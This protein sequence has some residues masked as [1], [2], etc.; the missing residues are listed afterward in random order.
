MAASR[1]DLSYR[2]SS[3]EEPTSPTTSI[4]CPIRRDLIEDEEP[5]DSYSFL[6]CLSP[7]G[8]SLHEALLEK[9]KTTETAYD[10]TTTVLVQ[11]GESPKCASLASLTNLAVEENKVE[12]YTRNDTASTQ[13]SNEENPPYT[14]TSLDAA[15]VGLMASGLAWVRRRKSNRYGGSRYPIDRKLQQRQEEIDASTELLQ[16]SS[17]DPSPGTPLR[18]AVSCPDGHQELEIKSCPTSPSFM[19]HASASPL[20]SL[21]KIPLASNSTINNTSKS[22]ASSPM[23]AELAPRLNPVNNIY[24]ISSLLTGSRQSNALPEDTQNDSPGGHVAFLQPESK[25]EEE[26]SIAPASVV[27]SLG[28]FCQDDSLKPKGNDKSPTRSALA[29]VFSRI[30]SEFTDQDLDE[31]STDEEEDIISES[32][33]EEDI[34][35]VAWIPQVRTVAE[36]TAR[37]NSCILTPLQMHQIARHVLPKGIAA[38]QWKCIYSLARD[39]DSFDVCLHYARNDR[40]TLLVVRTTRGAVFGG[41]AG[42]TWTRNGEAHYYGNNETCLFTFEEKKP[43]TLP[44]TEPEVVLPEDPPKEATTCEQGGSNGRHKD[45]ADGNSPTREERENIRPLE[46]DVKVT[47]TP[48][49]YERLTRSG[50]FPVTKDGNLPVTRARSTIAAPLSPPLVHR[51]KKSLVDDDEDS[52]EAS[53]PPIRV[54]KYKGVNRYIQYC[55]ANRKMLAFGGGG[56]E[57]SFGLCVQRE[58]QLGSTGHCDTFDNEPL[59]EQE[60]FKIVDVELWGFLTGQF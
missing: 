58:F 4:L 8:S 21:A 28:Y 42:E 32:E 16:S 49:R 22:V 27:P 11:D 12:L 17:K 38:C 33:S 47:L 1:F 41:Y 26:T 56:V 5:S 14:D 2:K 34:H 40:K 9:A 20:F 59:C 18:R 35:G 60:S 51:P 36:S 15:S 45:T 54:Y 55:D 48:T 46:S 25:E 39:G 29:R 50:T 6:A 44:P 10:T 23:K 37:V 31:V 13:D 43:D 24:S 7:S 52:Y 19:T 57:G 53:L 3:I 30:G